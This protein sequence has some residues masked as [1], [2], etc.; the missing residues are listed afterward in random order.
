MA[1]RL[2]VDYDVIAITQP[3]A[4]WSDV[5][6]VA[7]FNAVQA[8]LALRPTGAKVVSLVSNDLATAF[9]ANY[10][11][12]LLARFDAFV[13]AGPLTAADMR[14]IV[15]PYRVA[16]WPDFATYV[17]NCDTF[18][19]LVD[20]SVYTVV[21]WRSVVTGAGLHTDGVHMTTNAGLGLPAA[22]ASL[23]A[24]L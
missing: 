19:G 18:F 22:M 9:T 21:D 24:T 17:A 15:P 6:T 10:A 23:E 4:N 11:T 20:A 8:E 16:P 13:S 5:D 2:A 3:G 7:T 12:N 14:I 1:K